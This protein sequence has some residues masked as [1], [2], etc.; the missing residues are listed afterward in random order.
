MV[1]LNSLPGRKV[2]VNQGG[3]DT[4]NLVRANGGPHAATANG[5]AA[6]YLAGRHGLRQRRDIVGIIVVGYEFVRAKV[7]DFVTRPRSWATN[8]SF[9]PK[10]P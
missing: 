1:I 4:R 7:N 6:R 9:R 8:S 10:P 5:D 2:V 3:A